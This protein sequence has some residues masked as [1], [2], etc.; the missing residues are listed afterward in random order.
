MYLEIH[1]KYKLILNFGLKDKQSL[2]Y[3]ELLQSNANTMRLV[4]GIHIIYMIFT[5]WIN[6]Y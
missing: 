2:M 1:E 3:C 5:F 6:E 4:P